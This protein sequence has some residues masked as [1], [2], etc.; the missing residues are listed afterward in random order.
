MRNGKEASDHA[1]IRPNKFRH[2]DRVDSVPFVDDED[3]FA[4]VVKMDLQNAR[5]VSNR[6]EGVFEH[7]AVAA[8]GFDDPAVRHGERP[9]HVVSGDLMHQGGEFPFAGAWFG[10]AVGLGL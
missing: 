1:R 3:F 4:T 8:A 2:D 9:D 10:V 5:I 6:L 7:M